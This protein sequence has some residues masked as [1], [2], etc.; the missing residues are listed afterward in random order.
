[1]QRERTNT[2]R[3]IL[4]RYISA[5]LPFARKGCLLELEIT[6]IPRPGIGLLLSRFSKTLM[7]LTSAFHYGTLLKTKV[8]KLF[9]YFRGD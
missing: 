5:I 7:F 4:I 3:V 2:F 9:T 1:M 6:K 8:P